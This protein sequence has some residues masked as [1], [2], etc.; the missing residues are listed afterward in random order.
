VVPAQIQTRSRREKIKP[1][2]NR[3]VHLDTVLACDHEWQVGMIQE[4]AGSVSPR[5]AIAKWGE[6]SLNQFAPNP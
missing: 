3:R 6:I 2:A 4:N 5:F 1:A